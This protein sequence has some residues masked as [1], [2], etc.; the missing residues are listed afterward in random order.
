MTT[1]KCECGVINERL[2]KCT[3]CHRFVVQGKL[4][5]AWIYGLSSFVFV[6]LGFMSSIILQNSIGFIISIGGVPFILKCVKLN[7]EWKGENLIE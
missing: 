4:K 3:S 6:G 7:N 1:W 5:S 2:L